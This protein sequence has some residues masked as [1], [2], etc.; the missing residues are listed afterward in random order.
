[1]DYA[2]MLD[3]AMRAARQAGTIARTLIGKPEY[4]QWKS[5]RELVSGSVLPVQQKI[6]EIIK[7]DFPTHAILAEEGD[8]KPA[9]E[10]DPLWIVDPVDGTLNFSQ[11][12]PHLAISI[13]YREEGVYRVGVVYDPFRD[14]MFHALQGRYAR[15][16]GD[17]LFVKQVSEGEEAYNQAIV[18]TDL[19][20][21]FAERQQ[22]LNIAS[23]MANQCT[24]L[25]MMGSP[26]LGLCYV[27]AGRL[28]A[29]LALGLQI[30]DVAAASVILGESGGILTDIHGGSWLH[31]TG[32]YIASNGV[33]HGWMLRSAQA[34]LDFSKA[35]PA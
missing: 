30:W 14:E 31:T 21:G 15:L 16:N 25:T 4:L 17:S 5:P 23:L 1:M 29:Y 3:T 2:P 12:I 34:V 22:A 11:G 18:G 26:A 10:S 32:G 20:G 33:I 13:A 19:P 28:N 27:A 35:R 9:L 7:S 8:E 6:V 24:G